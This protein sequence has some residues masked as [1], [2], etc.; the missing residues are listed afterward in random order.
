MLKNE[1][2]FKVGGYVNGFKLLKLY[3]RFW[4]WERPSGVKK[5]FLPFEIPTQKETSE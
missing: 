4:L 2:E 5:C 3:G 1:K